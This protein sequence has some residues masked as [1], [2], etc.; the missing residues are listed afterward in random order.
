[1]A[2]NGWGEISER[3]RR[4]TV[5]IRGPNGRSAGSG[6]VWAADGTI[7]TNAHVVTASA[8]HVQFWDGEEVDAPVA[9]RDSHADLATLKVSLAQIQPAAWRDSREVRPGE[10]V[11]AIGNPLGFV[12]ALSTGVVHAVG[13]ISG[14]GRRPWEQAGVRLAPGNSGGPLADASGKVIGINT[15]VVHGL[16]LAIPSH[17][18]ARFV[19]RGGATFT[20]GVVVRPVSLQNLDPP[21]QGLLVL[22]VVDGSPAQYASLMPGDILIGVGGQPLGSVFDLGD[23]LD[24][25]PGL[26]RLQF[27]RGDR[28][29]VREAAVRLEHQVSEAA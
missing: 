20:L 19:D 21:S 4:S 3:L 24:T 22:E 15:M 14:L 29:Q 18:V 5:Q 6:V 1:M 2:R 12:G 11:M 26:M 16:G 25:S 28:R 23:A 27:L 9:Y 10:P 17:T 8:M 7:V 13:P